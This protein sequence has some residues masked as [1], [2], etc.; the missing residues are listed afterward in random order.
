MSSVTSSKARLWGLL[1][2]SGLSMVGDG[3][4][5]VATPW[6]ILKI[7]G[8][9]FDLGMALALQMTVGATVL[10]MGSPLADR[11][12][13]TKVAVTANVAS[14]GS[15]SLIPLAF[16]LNKLSLLVIV[17]ALS[18]AQGTQAPGVGARQRL[19]RSKAEAA[20]VSSRRANSVYW[21]L[22]QTGM[23]IGLP[24]GGVLIGALGAPSALGLDAVSFLIAAVMIVVVARN[25][26]AVAQ[27]VEDPRRR[28][29]YWSDLSMGVRVVVTTPALRFIGGCAL[30]LSGFD[31]ALVPVLLPVAIHHHH[32]SAQVL[33][34]LGGV[35]ATGMVIG[36]TVGSA[37]G[38]RISVR[39][40]AAISVSVVGIGYLLLG[41]DP[42]FMETG[43]GL[44]G[45]ASGPL[46]PLL[47]TTIQVSSPTEILS[48]VTG[49]M[50]AVLAVSAPV[51]VLVAGIAVRSW[52]VPTICYVGSGVF[53]IV[54]ATIAYRGAVLDPQDLAT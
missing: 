28:A 8:S 4:A 51:G 47:L 22:Q 12:N 44:I 49:A 20:G 54:A 42:H 53:L 45:L 35:Y 1:A 18:L 33:G 11:Y 31:G 43:I 52:S 25:E 14:A 2:A 9:P 17:V 40:L 19:I 3:V 6:L 26:D 24:V 39:R 32:Q 21:V 15:L 29:T 10:V 38:T 30:I 37:I 13:A 41:A 34:F 48:R 50:F 27:V 23:L 16:A 7:T 36:A 5:L 46:M